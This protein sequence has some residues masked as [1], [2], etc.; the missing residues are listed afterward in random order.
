MFIFSIHNANNLFTAQL[1]TEVLSINWA[2]MKKK[3]KCI[4]PFY[5]SPHIYT[6]TVL[7]I[8]NVEGVISKGVN[9]FFLYFSPAYY[10]M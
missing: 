6:S 2:K 1:E 10:R 7:F 5:K 8:Y 9:I 4:P 3:N